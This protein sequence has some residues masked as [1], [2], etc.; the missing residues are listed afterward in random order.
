MK[1]ALILLLFAVLL[2]GLLTACGNGSTPDEPTALEVPG[3]QTAP[4]ESGEQ[5]ALAETPPTDVEPPEENV[6]FPVTIEN[7][8]L[9]TTFYSAPERVVVFDYMA[10]QLFAALGLTDRIIALAPAA[11]DIIEVAEEFRSAI[12]AVYMFP[13]AHMT[14]GVPTFEIVLT[15]EP[16]FA[17]GNVFAFGQWGVG[18]AEDFIAASTNIYVLQGT[19]VDAPTLEN[20]YNDII[21]LGLIFDVQDRA[22]ALVADLRARESRIVSAV[23]GAGEVT[24]FNVDSIRAEDGTILT[25]GNANLLDYMINQAGGVN[26][27]NDVD[28]MFTRISLEELIMRDPEYIIITRYYYF[29]DEEEMKINFLTTTPELSGIT[30]VIEENFIVVPG[31]HLWPG[32]QSLDALETIARA[33]HPNAFN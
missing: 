25:V 29:D 28:A 1:N 30:A 9:S 19:Y 23:E 12:A 15:Y 5:T 14:N 31:L 8:G 27:F 21:N 20:I 4:E 22:E 11:D 3:T 18:E 13:D 33:L 10:A 6:A 32:I 26:V 2:I 17:I 7:F 16:D 24:V